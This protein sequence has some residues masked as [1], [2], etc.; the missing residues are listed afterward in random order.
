MVLGEKKN[1]E[2]WVSFLQ[3][4]DKF[5]KSTVINYNLGKRLARAYSP[6]CERILVAN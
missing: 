2:R 3:N 5:Q 1:E 6:L 4:L